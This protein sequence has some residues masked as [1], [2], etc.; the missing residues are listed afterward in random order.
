M[1]SAGKPCKPFV[2][3][4]CLPFVPPEGAYQAPLN[5]AQ[6]VSTNEE[7]VMTPML[8]ERDLKAEQRENKEA[9]ARAGHFAEL[10]APYLATQFGYKRNYV[11]L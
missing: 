11:T 8:E 6:P 4:I 1:A 10:L 3:S 9:R 5:G 7:Q 2:S